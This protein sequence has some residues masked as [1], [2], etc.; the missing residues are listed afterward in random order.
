M[1]TFEVRV[2][3]H[4]LPATLSMPDYAGA[5]VL[6]AHGS[7]SDRLAP[8]NAA[9]AEALNR[10]GLATLLID[11]LSPEEEA[12]RANVFDI[13]LLADRLSEAVGWAKAEPRTARLPLGLLGAGTGAAAALK[14]AARLGGQITAVVSRSGRPDLA[15]DVLGGVTAPSLLIVGGADETVLEL[16]AEAFGRLACEKA[17]K[18]VPG[19]SHLFPEPGAQEE[20]TALATRWFER[21]LL[22]RTDDWKAP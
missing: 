16:N 8:R 22:G 2:P 19:A 20:V 21:H 15:W 5:L 18:I 3:P 17:L 1:A 9:L 10:Q 7:A 14:A 11:L 12:D 4:G 6:F 13:D